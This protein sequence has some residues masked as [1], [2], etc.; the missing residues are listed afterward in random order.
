MATTSSSLY[1]WLEPSCMSVTC[2][3][4]RIRTSFHSR[5]THNNTLFRS[6]FNTKQ[7]P[8]IH[9][10]NLNFTF[11]FYY[12]FLFIV[13][14]GFYLFIYY[15]IKSLWVWFGSLSWVG[16][17]LS[18]VGRLIHFNSWLCLFTCFT[19]LVLFLF[20]CVKENYNVWLVGRVC[21]CVCPCAI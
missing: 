4:D 6:N 11:F 1:T 20:H 10:G 8:F 18:G 12:L 13:K 7:K 2:E 14:S 5:R 17:A 21:V 15:F 19:L 16:F 3:A 9:S